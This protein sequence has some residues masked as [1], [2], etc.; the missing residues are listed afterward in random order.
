MVERPIWMTSHGMTQY[1]LY[2]AGDLCNN[3][4]V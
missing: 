1:A 2:L 4:P 3:Q